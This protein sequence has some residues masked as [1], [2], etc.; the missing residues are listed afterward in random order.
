MDSIA[1]LNKMLI[2]GL[3]YCRQVFGGRE[4]FS[5]SLPLLTF[6]KN[7]SLLNPSLDPECAGGGGFKPWLTRQGTV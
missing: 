5:A 7:T 6:F 1:T 3:L 4:K 2:R